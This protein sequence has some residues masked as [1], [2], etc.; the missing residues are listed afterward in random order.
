M[1]KKEGGSKHDMR[2]ERRLKK[3]KRTLGKKQV[4]EITY[5]S[6]V[7]KMLM[8]A[9]RRVVMIPSLDPAA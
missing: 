2:E 5:P 6:A 1:E 8:I 3:R 7:G 4:P 9:H